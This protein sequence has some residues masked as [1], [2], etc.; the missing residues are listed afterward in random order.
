MMNS[1]PTVPAVDSMIYL[2]HICNI[3]NYI[4]SMKWKDIPLPREY[5][6]WGILITSCVIGVFLQQQQITWLTFSSLAGIAMLFMTKTPL[7]AFIRRRNNLALIFTF[8]YTASGLL[9]LAP[10]LLQMSV[11]NIL[12]IS[13]IPLLTVVVYAL[14]AYLHKERA[15]VVEFS[16]M[17]TLTLPVLFFPIQSNTPMDSGIVSLWFL[18]F[19]YFSASIFKVK[20]LLF[21][22]HFYR[23][24]SLIYLGIVFLFLSILIYLHRVPELTGAAFLPLL[25]NVSSTFYRF[26]GKKNL[27]LVG[28][29]ELIKGTVFAVIIIVA[30]R[31]TFKI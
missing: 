9:L 3:R 13:V 16:A 23:V 17:A 12:I 5:G 15:S 26:G 30:A 25:D 24:A 19:L 22:K 4:V 29:F 6:S 11:Q 2:I 10:A 18:S 14:S 8:I 1:G 7:S 28:I 20:M 31:S 21:R 27:K